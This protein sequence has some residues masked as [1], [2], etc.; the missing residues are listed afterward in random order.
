MV[1]VVVSNKLSLPHGKPGIRRDRSITEMVPYGCPRNS[2]GSEL[3][4]QANQQAS[5]V[6]KP[7]PP[8]CQKKLKYTGFV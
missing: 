6:P 2:V 4:Q 8:A 7:L 5:G 3:E 1:D